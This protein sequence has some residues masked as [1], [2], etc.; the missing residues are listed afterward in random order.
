VIDDLM[1]NPLVRKYTP[2]VA[3]IVFIALFV[4]LAFW[5]LDRA[6]EKKTLLDLFG[7]DAPYAATENFDSLAAFDRIQVD[8]RFLGD[9]QVLID[10]IALNSRQ[11]Y[12]VITP[13]RTSIHDNL[14]LVNRG[15]VPK[16]A[17]KSSAPTIDVDASQRTVRGMAGHLPRV[18]IRPGEAFEGSKDWPRIAVFPILDEFATELAEPV[19]PVVLL[20][21]PDEKDGFARRWQPDISGPMMHYGYAFQWFAMAATILAILVWHLRKWRSRDSTSH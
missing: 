15:W 8:G 2:P 21:S 16:D 4:F 19:L 6:A 18:G 1:E 10:N 12:Y 20:M 11:G 13:F 3:G 14:L 7:G 5:Q 17:F 9:Q